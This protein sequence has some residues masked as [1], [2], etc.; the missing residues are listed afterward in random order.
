MSL[1]FTDSWDHYAV[2]DSLKKW[3]GSSSLG[4]LLINNSGRNGKCLEIGNN[5][6]LYKILDAQA[7]WIVGFAWKAAFANSSANLLIEFVDGSVVHGYLTTDASGH[8]RAFRGD[9]TIL[10]TGTTVLTSSVWYHIQVKFTVHDSTG[11]FIVKLNGV[12]E[13]NLTGQDTRN[14]GNASANTIQVG[15]GNNAGSNT[16]YWDDFWLMDAQGSVNNDFPAD[17]DCK[18]ECLL[19]SGAGN[20]A[21]WTPSAGSNYQNVDDASANGDTDYNSDGTSGHIDSYAMGN[22]ATSAGTILGVQ[23]NLWARKDDAGSI[24]IKPHFRISSTDYA[25]TTVAMAD[26]YADYMAIE[27]VSPATSSPWTVSEV[28]GLEFGVK[29]A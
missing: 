21:Q 17:G 12:T 20:Y 4:G 11:V 18:V 13:L 2:G 25:R 22:L 6:S 5:Q 10:G 16:Q 14:G 28:N 1:R 24:S 7:T 26:T 8:L 9:G 29:V 19:P 27:E 3:S 23:T 15:S